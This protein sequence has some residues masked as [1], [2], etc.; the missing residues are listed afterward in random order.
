MWEVLSSGR[1]SLTP[2]EP[3]FL[4]AR[5]GRPGFFEISDGHH[6]VASGLRQGRTSF[7]AVIDLTPD[8]EP[9]EAP[10]FNFDAYSAATSLVSGM[11]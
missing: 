11:V 2:D 3:L 10:F 9:Y 1:V 4:T 8:E 5:A 7:L 6:R